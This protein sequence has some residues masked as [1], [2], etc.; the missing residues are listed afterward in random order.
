MRNDRGFT[1]L[2]IL[3]TAMIFSVFI[4][5]I[6]T[7]YPTTSLVGKSGRHVASATRLAEEKMEEISARGFAYVT[8][9]AFAGSESF[10]QGGATFTRTVTVTPCAADSNPPC[11]GNANLIRVAV[12]V[13]WSD[14]SSP[15]VRNISLTTI[16]HRF[17]YQFS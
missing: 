10:T 7:T 14:A 8:P 6:G 16:I 4:I 12:R 9:A 15:T 1:I 13:Q 2:E 11:K 17:F 5:A 3:V